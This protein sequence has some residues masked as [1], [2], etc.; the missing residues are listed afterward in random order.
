MLVAHE[1]TETTLMLRK[2]RWQGVP[3][4]RKPRFKKGQIVQWKGFGKV[5]ILAAKIT[6]AEDVWILYQ[7]RSAVR[8]FSFG[9]RW[10]EQWELTE[11]D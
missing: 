5:K 4:W 9:T 11:D 1:T 10:V 8:G 7:I 3:V 6:G 2:P